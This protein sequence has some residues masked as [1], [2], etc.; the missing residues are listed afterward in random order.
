MASA[1]LGIRPVT[2]LGHQV[3]RRVFLEKPT[4]IKLCPAHFSR[5]AKIFAG[6]LH[7][8]G[9]APAGDVPSTGVGN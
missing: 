1:P 2:S 5:G 4:F 8:P 9:Y 6:G 7:S 3:G